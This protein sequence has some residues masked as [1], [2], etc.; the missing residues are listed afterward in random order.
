[1]AE[2]AITMPVV[3]MVLMFSINVSLASYSAVSAAGAANYGARVGAVSEL[4]SQ[5]YAMAAVKKAVGNSGAG[6]EFYY[7]VKTDDS[8]GG[9]V[10][11]VVFWRYPSYFSGLCSLFGGSCPRYFSG[12]ASSVWKK[13]GL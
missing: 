13:E 5:E 7:F 8:I 10:L 2:A 12:S 1:M 9:G 6:G 3:M 11:V 4:N